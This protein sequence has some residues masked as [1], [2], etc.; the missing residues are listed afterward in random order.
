MNT[1]G[2]IEGEGHGVGDTASLICEIGFVPSDATQI[3]CTEDG[4]YSYNFYFLC[5]VYFISFVSLGGVRH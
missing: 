5:F 4:K 1:T 2:Y 3:T